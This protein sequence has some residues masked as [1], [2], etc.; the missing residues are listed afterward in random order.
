MRHWSLRVPPNLPVHA[1]GMHFND[2][3]GLHG[4]VAIPIVQE[5]GGSGRRS[6]YIVGP[7]GRSIDHAA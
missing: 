3:A 5:G 7:E 4:I 1:F 2:L 6:S